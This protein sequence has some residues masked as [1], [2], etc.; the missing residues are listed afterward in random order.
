LFIY[1]RVNPHFVIMAILCTFF[2]C[3][4]HLIQSAILPP[5]VFCP[6]VSSCVMLPLQT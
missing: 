6:S 4:M 2:C 5:Q 3:A 1:I